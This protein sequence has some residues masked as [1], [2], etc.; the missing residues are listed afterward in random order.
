MSVPSLSGTLSARY[1]K[2]AGVPAD[3]DLGPTPPRR[4]REITAD[5]ACRPRPDN[6]RTRWGGFAQCWTL[7]SSHAAA[8]VSLR[9]QGL[10]AEAANLPMRQS[11]T[12]EAGPWPERAAFEC[13]STDSRFPKRLV[14]WRRGTYV[15][16]KGCWRLRRMGTRTRVMVLRAKRRQPD[17]VPL[18]T[19]RPN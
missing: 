18:I 1:R 9:S 10:M 5:L 16:P 2:R 13:R 3:T 15:G 8:T 12:T 7:M 11:T 4:P 19:Q 14:T 6:Y 17:L